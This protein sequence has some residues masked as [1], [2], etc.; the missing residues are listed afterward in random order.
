M[1]INWGIVIFIIIFIIVFGSIVFLG[2]EGQKTMNQKIDFCES[3][4]G[5]AEQGYGVDCL[6]QIQE[7]D[8]YQSYYQNYRIGWKWNNGEKEFYLI[9]K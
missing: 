7:G 8:Y 9:R 3:I 5:I 2:I 4:N 6:I 1:K